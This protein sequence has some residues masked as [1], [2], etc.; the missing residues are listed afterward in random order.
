[1]EQLCVFTQDYQ[2]TKHRLKRVNGLRF[3][4][5]INGCFQAM[6]SLTRRTDSPYDDLGLNYNLYIK[7]QRGDILWQGRIETIEPM[8]EDGGLTGNT[9]IVQALGYWAS[10]RDLTFNGTISTAAPET[11]LASLISGGYLPHLSSDT[12]GLVSTGV[13]S[14]AYQ[15]DDGGTRDVKIDEVIKTICERGNSVNSKVIA[16]VDERRRLCTRVISPTATPKYT[17]KKSR[18]KGI[19]PRK[20][21][22]GIYSNISVRYK[23]SAD[24]KLTRVTATDSATETKFTIKYT[25]AGSSASFRRTRVA[26]LTGLSANNSGIATAQAT[27]YASSLLAYGKRVKTESTSLSVSS[28]YSIFDTELVQPIKLYNIRPGYYL[29]V[30]DIYPRPSGGGSIGE[31]Y[32]TTIFLITQVEYEEETGALTIT[33]EVSSDLSDQ[34]AAE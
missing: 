33:P 27:D 17:V 2:A 5:D 14:N 12:S 8:V 9:V 31:A 22:S 11:Q 25:P 6:F 29:K 4:W 24:G 21:L 23:N 7:N 20:S 3:S 34:I 1:M 28:E 19:Q 15:T 18:V 32:A 13:A 16:Y 30:T 10:T 26:D